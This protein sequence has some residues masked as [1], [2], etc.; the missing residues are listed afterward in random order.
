[1]ETIFVERWRLGPVS[2]NCELHLPDSGLWIWV[3]HRSGARRPEELT[4]SVREGCPKLGRIEERE[5]VKH[6]WAILLAYSPTGQDKRHCHNTRLFLKLQRSVKS[7]QN[8]CS[9]SNSFQQPLS[10]AL[11]L[12][13]L[14]PAVHL[15]PTDAHMHARQTELCP[16]LPLARALHL[17]SQGTSWSKV[18]H[19]PVCAAGWRAEFSGS[20]GKPL[21]CGPPNYG[22][23]H[24]PLCF[25]MRLLSTEMSLSGF[26][27]FSASIH[28][29][30]FSQHNKALNPSES[31]RVISAPAC[32]PTAL[33]PCW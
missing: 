4:R 24:F 18:V 12:C 10:H 33:L 27:K 13:P 1:M 2:S 9:R 26:F 20:D 16:A 21:S 17:R 30:A 8:L 5:A 6:V 23:F 15:Q 19:K 29:V 14:F 25:M 7:A 31:Q 32:T 28:S 3:H 22:N 11:L